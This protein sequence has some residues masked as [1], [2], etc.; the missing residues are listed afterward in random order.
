[1]SFQSSAYPEQLR[2]LSDAP[3]VL[4]GIGDPACLVAGLAVVGA[5]RATP[6][7]TQ[8]ARILASWSA[9]AGYVIYS[10]GAIGCDQAAHQAALDA[11]G[12]TVAVM[13]CG[14]DVVYPRGASDL[15]ARIAR[16]GAIV[17]EHPWG[18]Q[19]QRWT[20]RTRNRIIAA[21][22][23]AVLI[24]EAGL[25]SGTFSTAEYALDVGRDVL[26]VPGSVFAPECAGTNR[27]I[28][29]GATPITEAD[30]LRLA[31]EPLLGP[32]ATPAPAWAPAAAAS[33]DRIAAALR[34][35]PMRPDDIARSL[36]LDIVA[37]VQ[38]I[39]MLETMGAVVR[40]RDGRYGPRA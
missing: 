36:G 33:E 12:A 14:A 39:G 40:Y 5:R 23:A 37:V 3:P 16:S 11:G 29:T 7:G 17:S 30:D 38:R 18:T 2:A 34:T 24:L 21:L 32:A 27:L 10:G 13:G 31:L 15:M 19:P 4:Y 28:R 22:S 9:Q 26:A 6:Y 8:C 35:N 1:M 20:F 25:G